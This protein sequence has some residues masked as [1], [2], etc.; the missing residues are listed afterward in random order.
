MEQL[1]SWGWHGVLLLGV[2]MTIWRV[3]PVAFDAWNSGNLIVGTVKTVG[4]IVSI[5]VLAIGGY[6]VIRESLAYIATDAKQSGFY[7]DITAW[8]NSGSTSFDSAASDVGSYFES[9]KSEYNSAVTEAGR[10]DLTIENTLSESQS[11]PQSAGNYTESNDLPSA[12][13]SNVT[14]PAVR[15]N[16]VSPAPAPTRVVGVHAAQMN[17]T[18]VLAPDEVQNMAEYNAKVGEQARKAAAESG[19]SSSLNGNSETLMF[20][21]GGGPTT[22]QAD[23]AV[24]MATGGIYIVQR[25]DDL[26]KISRI[27]YGTTAHAMAICKAN[28]LR[29]CNVVAVGKRLVIP[30]IN[31]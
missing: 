5:G 2:L 8:G 21:G 24:T 15:S 26:S 4:P 7:N 18:N 1:F 29:N 30:A 12:S 16:G 19:D 3:I 14:A 13:Q 11:E 9:F 6:M 17:T 10:A 25:G 28:N 22:Q 20:V 27:A 23:Q 31:Q